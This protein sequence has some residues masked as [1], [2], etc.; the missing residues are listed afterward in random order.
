M[1]RRNYRSSLARRRF[2]RSDVSWISSSP[3]RSEIN[4][5]VRI[6]LDSTQNSARF[7]KS[8]VKRKRSS[9]SAGVGNRL[10]SIIWWS[11]LKAWIPA[12]FTRRCSH[13]TPGSSRLAR[14]GN[15]RGFSGSYP[16]IERGSGMN[17]SNS[18]MPWGATSAPQT[19]V[20]RFTRESKRAWSW[21]CFRES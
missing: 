4:R 5:I 18:T 11:F 8:T 15:I 6:F 16:C 2:S 3:R 1:S 17:C 19:S 10:L 9:I 13:N 14:A 21:N 20:T 7:T 12:L